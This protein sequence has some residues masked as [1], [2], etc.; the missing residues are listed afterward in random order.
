MSPRPG[1]LSRLRWRR[2]DT[3]RQL[4]GS[5]GEA[6]TE[7]R[8]P[9]DPLLGTQAPVTPLAGDAASEAAHWLG[10]HGGKTDPCVW[11]K[12]LERETGTLHPGSRSGTCVL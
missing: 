9:L 10:G 4:G 7:R 2:T 8:G 6:Q 5:V 3:G 12:G 1:S 11:A